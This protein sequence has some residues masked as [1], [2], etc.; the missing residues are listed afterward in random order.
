L[1]KKHKLTNK[2]TDIHTETLIATLHHLPGAKK[3]GR[4]IRGPKHG[5]G[6]VQVF[7]SPL[8]VFNISII[9]ILHVE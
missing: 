8:D 2:Q 4:V 9:F 6:R 7:G 5:A 1:F 3:I